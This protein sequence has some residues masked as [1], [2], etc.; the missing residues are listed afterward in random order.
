MIKIVNFMLC[1]FYQNKNIEKKAK[2]K[3]ELTDTYNT[4]KPVHT[5]WNKLVTK[6]IDYT[7]YLK[8]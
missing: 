7:I 5:K 2:N 1:V 4:D 8:W 6:P 3:N